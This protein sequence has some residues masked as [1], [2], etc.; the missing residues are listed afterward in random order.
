MDHSDVPI[1][2]PKTGA[3]EHVVK[4]KGNYFLKR[5]KYLRTSM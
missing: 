1:Y 5:N 4:L 3:K 2:P